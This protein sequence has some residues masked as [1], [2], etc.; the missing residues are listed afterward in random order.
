VGSFGD[1]QQNPG[2]RTRAWAPASGKAAGTARLVLKTDSFFQSA[3]SLE[4]S[5]SKEETTTLTQRGR[6]DG[7]RDKAPGLYPSAY[8]LCDQKTPIRTEKQIFQ[9]T[10]RL[11]LVAKKVLV[12][13]LLYLH[14]LR[15]P[16]PVLAGQVPDINTHTLRGIEWVIGGEAHLIAHSQ[17][18]VDTQC[19]Q[20]DGQ[21]RVAVNLFCRAGMRQVA[22]QSDQG[23]TPGID[24][25]SSLILPVSLWRPG[26]DEHMGRAGLGVKRAHCHIAA[27][28]AESDLIHKDVWHIQGTAGRPPVVLGMPPGVYDSV[29]LQKKSAAVRTETGTGFYG[30]ARLYPD[31]QGV[32]LVVWRF[33]PDFGLGVR[34]GEQLLPTGAPLGK[35]DGFFVF[36]AKHFAP[37]AIRASLV[38][39]GGLLTYSD[40]VLLIRSQTAFV[41]MGCG[42]VHILLVDIDAEFIRVGSGLR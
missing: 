11:F 38:Q 8:I 2:T 18:P 1:A 39:R 4:S 9:Q 25:Q 28:Q 17:L 31:A 42:C 14:E 19:Q 16:F 36:Q 30:M 40:K 21:P 7:W 27:I 41:L 26:P 10:T 3:L 5:S 32:P 29:A 6:P 22:W 13:R 35:T 23:I 37:D 12:A 20:F 15:L 33:G 24:N 34:Q